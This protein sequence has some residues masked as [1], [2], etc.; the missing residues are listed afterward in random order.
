MVRPWREIG[1][2]VQDTPPKAHIKVLWTCR[3]VCGNEFTEILAGVV[4]S[5][6]ICSELRSQYTS[7][8]W[9]ALPGPHMCQPAR[10]LESSR[11]YLESSQ[12][13]NFSIESF[14]RIR[15]R[16]NF[17]SKVSKE[18]NSESKVSKEF[19]SVSVRVTCGPIGISTE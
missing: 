4:L 15:F 1:E 2:N 13:E 11:K 19:N 10:R 8:R 6:I 14:K 18:F 3:G 9:P 7:P 16:A 12:L 17:Q 5:A